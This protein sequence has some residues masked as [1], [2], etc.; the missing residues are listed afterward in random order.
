M[1]KRDD[2]AWRPTARMRLAG[3][4]PTSTLPRGGGRGKKR[5]AGSRS[6]GILRAV[7]RGTVEP[8][9][10]LGGRVGVGGD[11]RSLF[12]QTL[13]P[14]PLHS[15]GNCTEIRP[16]RKRAC[17]S[18]FDG[19]NSTGIGFAGR[20]PSARTSW[21]FC[22]CRRGS[23]SKWMGVSTPLRRIAMLN[24]RRGSNRKGS[25]SCDFGTTMC[26]AIL[27]PWW[28]RSGTRSGIETMRLAGYP[29]T[30]TLPRGGGRGKKGAR[31]TA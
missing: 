6:L 15:P 2:A 31:A 4:P 21:I 13:Q 24:G 20:F 19:N 25:G 29:P 18:V 14:W 9:P 10:P 7:T 11:S 3:H 17:G 23:L 8:P 28:R 22:A 16:R 5:G 1:P 26:L 30:P 12:E 27:M